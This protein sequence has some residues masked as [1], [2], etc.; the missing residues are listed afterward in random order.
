MQIQRVALSGGRPKRQPGRA[1]RSRIRLHIRSLIWRTAFIVPFVLT[2]LVSVAPSSVHASGSPWS[3]SGPTAVAANDGT[4]GTAK[5]QYAY[6]PCP[7]HVEG[8]CTGASGTWGF[9][10]TADRS[11]HVKL[12]WDYSGFHAFF[13]V[14]VGLHAYVH[15]PGAPAAITDLTLVNDGP[16]VCCTPPSSGFTYSGSTELDVQ[17]GDTYGFA[18]SGSNADFNTDLHGTLTVDRAFIDTIQTAPNLTVNTADDHNDGGCTVNDCSLA[19]AISLSNDSPALVN[20]ITF[21]IPG[22][23]LQTI[24]LHGALPTIANPVIIR[25]DSQAGSDCS[26]PATGLKVELQSR[27]EGTNPALTFSGS[28][29]GS[30]VRGLI[31]DGFA[32]D[33]I[34][35]SPTSDGASN[36]T[37][38]CDQIGTAALPNGGSG[39]RLTNVSDALVGSDQNGTDDASETN[40]IAYNG[41]DG[42]QILNDGSA[43][44]GDR[45]DGNVIHDNDQLGIDLGGDGVTPNDAGD[46]D[47]GPNGLNNFPVLVRA[48]GGGGGGISGRLDTTNDPAGQDVTLFIADTCD[49]SGHGE[50]GV[51]VGT[52]HVTPDA[53]GV[54]AFSIALTGLPAGKFVTAVATDAA[55]ST[56]EYS[57]CLKIGAGND[58][59]P[60]ALDISGTGSASD[61]LEYSGQTRWYKFQIDPQAQVSVNLT[62]LPADYDLIL[63]KDISQA[64][65][66]LTQSSDLTKLSAEFST[67]GQ[68]FSGTGQKFS[69]TGQKFSDDVFSGTGQKFSGTGQKF[70]GDLGFSGDVFSGT[71]QKFSGDAFS[72]TGQ[73]FS[74]DTSGTGQKFSPDAYSS[75]QSR[76]VIDF[77]AVTG[78]GPE[79]ITSDTWNNTGFFYVRVSGRS[80]VF[81]PVNP[82]SLHVT[83]TSTACGG[84]STYS[85]DSIAGP[86]ATGPF[87]TIILTDPTRIAG[88]TG[89]KATLAS[90]LTAFASR[91]EVGGLVIN[92]DSIPRIHALNAQ[93]DANP[94]CPYA[95]NLV[96]TALKTVIDSYRASN[97]LAYVVLVGGDGTI[98]FFRYPDTADLAPESG[99][100]PP[101]SPLSA[102]EASLQLNYVLS[103]DAYGAGTQIA[104]GVS[105]F[106]VPDLAVGRLVETAREASIVLEAY[107]THTTGGVVATPTHSLV[108][109]YDFMADAA[110]SVQADF[111]AGLGSSTNADSLIAPNNILPTDPQSWTAAQLRAKLLGST[112]NDLIFLAGHFSTNT[113]L[114]ADFSTTIQASDL[115]ASATDFTNTIVF[116]QGCH[117]GYNLVD[118]DAIPNVT[119]QLDWAQAFA[120]KGATLIAGTGYQYGDTDL[121]QYSEAIYSGFAHELRLGSGPV[122]VGQALI[123]AKQ[124][125]LRNTPVLDSIDTKALLESTLFGLPM[126]Q[127][128]LPSNRQGA[129]TDGAGVSPNPVASGPGVAL[130]LTSTD[131]PVNTSPLT[132]NTKPLT[133]IDGAASATATWYSGPDGVV[134]GPSQ[135]AL[136]LVS[137]NVTAPG[138]TLRGVGFRGGTYTDTPG[139]T[140]LLSAPA[141][142]VRTAHTSFNSPTFFP[143][144]L[145]N[146]NYFD[147]LGNGATRLLIT[148]AQHRSDGPTSP[149]STLRL[150]SGVDFRL[151]YSNNLGPAALTSAP[152]ILDVSASA[153]GNVVT[154]DAHVVG[155]PAAGIQ[156]VWITY[157][158]V[159]G[160]HTWTSLDLAQDPTDPSHWM[161]SH[162]FGVSPLSIQFM[163][164]AVNGVG[165]VALDTD[166]G[167]FY[168]LAQA[169]AANPNTTTVTLDSGNASH[170]V[171]GSTVT[172]SA[173]LHSATP[174]LGQ[175][176]EFDLANSVRTALTDSSGHASVTFTLT[177][178]PGTEPLTA[179]FLGDAQNL[180]SLATTTFAIDKLGTHLALSGPP[181]G[182]TGSVSGI[183]ASLTDASVIP[184]PLGQRS[185]FFVVSQHG[186]P[187]NAFSRSVITDYLGHAA[188]GSIG[189]APG[190]YDVAAYFNGAITLLPAATVVSITDD[191]YVNTSA[192]TSY[193][194]VPA[195]PT[196]TFD[197][198][199]LPAKAFGSAPFSV[200]SFVTTNSP[201]TQTFALGGGSVG[202]TVSVAGMVTLTGAAVDPQ[203]CVISVS[204]AAG[205]GFTAAGPVSAS[206]HVARATPTLTLAVLPD[207][208]LGTG[209]FSITSAATSTG[210]ATITFATG[211]GSVGCTINA[212]GTILTLTAPALG[213][214]FCV[215]TVTQ[216]ANADYN[217]PA[218]ATQQFHVSKRV[219]AIAVTSVAPAAA[220]YG[221]TYTPTATGGG[222]GNPVTFS[223]SGA[224]SFASGTITMTASGTCTVTANQAGNATYDP[225]AAVTQAFAV[226]RKG[227]TLGYTGNLFWSAGSG[228]TASV[229]LTGQVTRAAGGTTLATNATV[230]FLLFRSGNVTAT[231]DDHC[232]GTVNSAG[233]ATCTKSLAL[234]NW[235]VVMTIPAANAFFTAPNADPV[236]LTVYQASA[237]KYATGAGWVI[238]PSYH[239]IPV[240]V[241][242]TK[243]HGIFGFAVSYK[244]GTTPQGAAVYEFRGNDGY[245]YVF[246]TT[247]WTGGGL[248]FGTGTASFSAKCSVVAF[249]PATHKVVSGKGGTNFTCRFDVTDGATDKFAMSAYTAAGVLYHQVGTSASQISLGSGSIVVKK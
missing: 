182:P 219:Q 12:D 173:T 62:D 188:L 207:R 5:L 245:D 242:P 198:T 65:S 14:R 159:G 168:T 190:T 201:G 46:T 13:E 43:S 148:P 237:A 132:I 53:T 59:W 220:V 225:A 70:S 164:Q 153:L 185:V 85:G 216:P 150:F 57:A 87:K 199:A 189:L 136:P 51:I 193:L 52:A 91:S 151:F 156:G 233:V 81:D 213:T 128:N 34:D 169:T 209:P 208:T 120:Q 33:G 90:D 143:A 102:S 180:T 145:G 227:A 25:G 64:Y 167:H 129:P 66:T 229:T 125:Y 58:S 73:K 50:G 116:S 118:G 157:T 121:I 23:G 114:A 141:T 56:S 221:D 184:V 177:D 247:S 200:A 181:S 123:R 74:P 11:G 146:P 1:V 45:L 48:E 77:S 84:L 162:D 78:A 49:P 170:A 35:V 155:D 139:I 19:E 186:N 165:L 110:A 86:V 113:A 119:D 235:T 137:K 29:A 226:G 30:Q 80:G 55:G 21:A 194:V 94:A 202:C 197:L 195:T 3:A 24:V 205:A 15:R 178:V 138:T 223:G 104:Q 60:N 238:D 27:Y 211:S 47:T 163:A 204:L 67:T 131:L 97:P 236:V 111:S 224:C 230:D 4:D 140:P 228:T 72:G 171:F 2:G 174:L 214:S 38:Q 212:A 231:P 89:D 152:S 187:A 75:A 9:E 6:D 154:F 108:T 105:T 54:S 109:G 22:D 95:K 117:A 63:F 206:F 8:T 244:S 172:F 203:S 144:Q 183:V 122:S 39:I 191:T 196:L 149:T 234:D 115:A 222:S 215:I 210:P 32:G 92:V 192:S 241:S 232:L 31:I 135:P 17:V 76:S 36:V 37:I 42:I 175:P 101:V 246:T 16:A 20:T 248:S 240:K 103:Q 10:T 44:T 147:A 99:Y 130:G 243:N 239:D 88:S 176:I 71:G 68:K 142:E 61:A 26:S 158:G 127:V 79:S 133:G 96:A 126:L 69:G 106:P 82:F 166:F 218:V 18:L 217:A 28:V 161:G 134:S 107:L 7:S 41:G 40:V 179:T 112:H 83:Q 100:I 98:P 160:G 124:D 93:A 249:N